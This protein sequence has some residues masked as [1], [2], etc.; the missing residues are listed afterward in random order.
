MTSPAHDARYVWGVSYGVAALGWLV[1]SAPWLF[2]DVT[3]PYDAKA[4][5]HPQIQFLASSLH[6]GQ[7]P[8]WNPHIFAGS[9]QI[10]D[11]QSLI[12]SPASVIGMVTP[13]VGLKALDAYVL[14]MGRARGIVGDVILPRSRLASSRRAG[15]RLWRCVRGI[16]SMADTACRPDSELC[17][18]SLWRFGCWPGSL[19]RRSL[20]YGVATGVA[21]GLMIAQPIRSPISA[22]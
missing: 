5:F 14:V 20:A 10:A 18:A 3:V 19:G 13:R 7:S 21:I 9:P 15:G 8:F 12:F 22:A 6:S 11:P 16:G 2:G 4:H 1:L 17:P